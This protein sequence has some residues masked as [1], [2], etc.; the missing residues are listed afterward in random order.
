MP[1]PDARESSFACSWRSPALW[2]ASGAVASVV[3]LIL[4]PVFARA[5]GSTHPVNGK[6][7]WAPCVLLFHGPTPETPPTAQVREGDSFESGTVVV[8]SALSPS[9]DGEATWWVRAG[10]MRF[11]S[12]HGGLERLLC[13]ARY[14]I[15]RMPKWEPE[16]LWV[17]ID[18]PGAE[19]VT[20]AVRL[21]DVD[22]QAVEFDVWYPE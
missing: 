10:V 21:A 17:G 15:R 18:A 1:P 3:V 8:E 12:K 2:I 13:D 6:S 7:A 9:A 22:R 19:R 11:Y 5:S 16:K 4:F 20:P 14:A